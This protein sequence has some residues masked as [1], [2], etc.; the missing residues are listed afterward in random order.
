MLTAWHR[1]LRQDLD[2]A[3][4]IVMH[5]EARRGVCG[6]LVDVF[7]RERPAIWKH[8]AFVRQGHL[9]RRETQIQRDN[10]RAS[11]LTSGRDEG[12]HVVVR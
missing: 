4:P 1:S 7:P 2:L 5:D 3:D 6:D 11:A 12:L 8:D 10:G 9:V